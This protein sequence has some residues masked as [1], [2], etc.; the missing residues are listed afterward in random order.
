MGLFSSSA[1]AMVFLAISEWNIIR[2]DLDALWNHRGDWRFAGSAI[3]L[4]TH[5]ILSDWRYFT[6]VPSEDIRRFIGEKAH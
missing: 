1:M 2:I 5:R 3:A 4:M 6:R